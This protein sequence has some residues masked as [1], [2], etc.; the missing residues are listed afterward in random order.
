MKNKVASFIDYLEVIAKW[1]FFVIRNVFVLSMIAVII[2][3]MLVKKY[4]STATIL[5]PGQD[6]SMMIGLISAGLPGGLSNIPGISS[7]LPGLATPSDLY[8]AI[9][10]SGSIRSAII[11]KHNLQQEFQTSTMYDTYAMLEEITGITVSPEGIIAVSITYKDKNLTAAIANSYIEELDRFNTETAMTAGKKYRIFIEERLKD[12]TDSLAAAEQALRQFQEEHKTIA[13]EVEIENAIATIVELKSQVILLEV[14]KGALSSASKYNNPY[15]YEINRELR[16]LKRQ[17]SLI[18]FGPEQPDSINKQ[19]G[20]GFSI[21][22]NELP[23]IS[24]EYIRLVRDVKVQ[25]VIY[26]LLTQQ[27]EQA[28]IMELKD[29]PTVQI[30]DR[31]SPPEKRSFPK[32]GII[33]FVVFIASIAL[34]I[35]LVFSIEFVRQERKEEKSVVNRFISLLNTVKHDIIRIK[36]SIKK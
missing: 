24:L 13:L 35:L 36:K 29:T 32:R 26:E 3:L 25:E 22:F 2:S 15:L 18:E 11:K 33:V 12:N 31:A 7:I 6:Q 34:N 4:T 28:K 5:P 9:L 27:Y 8:A 14:K 19:F 21:P 16:E 10:K 20:A 23:E 17:L 1:R 30:L